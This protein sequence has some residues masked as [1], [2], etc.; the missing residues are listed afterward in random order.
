MCAFFF[1]GFAVYY[2]YRLWFFCYDVGLTRKVC[3]FSSYFKL[4]SVLYFH[5]VPFFD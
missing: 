4:V 3:S 1:P 5:R 2:N